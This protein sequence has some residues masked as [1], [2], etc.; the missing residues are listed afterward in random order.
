MKLPWIGNVS[1]GDVELTYRDGLTGREIFTKL[2][3]VS[4]YDR[5]G[6]WKRK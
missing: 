5:H 6:W 4:C 1:I 3:H 2:D